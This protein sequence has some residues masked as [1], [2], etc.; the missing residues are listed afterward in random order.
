MSN[1]GEELQ[2][3]IKYTYYET[4]QVK[5][6]EHGDKCGLYEREQGYTRSRKM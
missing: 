3:I 2:N 1:S 6:D 5:W 4:G